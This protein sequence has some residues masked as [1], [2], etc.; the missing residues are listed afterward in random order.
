VENYTPLVLRKEYMWNGWGSSGSNSQSEWLTV[1][2]VNVFSMCT[3]V[4]TVPFL[5]LNRKFTC[6]SKISF[7]RNLTHNSSLVQ[8]HRLFWWKWYVNNTLIVSDVMTYVG[9]ETSLNHRLF[10][11]KWYVN[12]TLIVTD[13]MTY[14]YWRLFA[15]FLFRLFKSQ[16]L[17]ETSN[18]ILKHLL[19]PAYL[20]K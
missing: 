16:Q 14:L 9:F 4:R 20:L 17:F 18:F 3:C 7:N 6:L 8:N 15:L 10:W 12:Y 11:W 1:R 13:L 19:I 2:Y 5:A